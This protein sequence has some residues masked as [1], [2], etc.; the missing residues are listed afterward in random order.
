MVPTLAELDEEQQALPGR[1][2]VRFQKP[3]EQTKGGIFIPEMAKGIEYPVAKVVSLG[4]PV[5]K[6]HEAY[7]DVL[8]KGD[9]VGANPLLGTQYEVTRDIEGGGAAFR[10][11]VVYH[12]YTYEQLTGLVSDRMKRFYEDILDG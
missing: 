3:A 11:S 4:R 2:V 5:T 8:G 9:L 10:D 1:V 6:T 7:L 12:I